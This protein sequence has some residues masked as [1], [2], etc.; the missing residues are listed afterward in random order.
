MKAEEIREAVLI[1]TGLL[2]LLPL[3]AAW[4]KDPD[5]PVGRR[6]ALDDFTFTYAPSAQALYHARQGAGCPADALL[7]VE[8]PDG[9]LHFTGPEVS[10]VLSHFPGRSV[11]L[12]RAQATKK[13]VVQAVGSSSVLHFSGHGLAGWGEAESSLLKLADGSLTLLEIF[14]LNLDQARLAVLSACETGVPG[15]KLPDEAV[16]LPSAWMQAGVP[17]VVGSLWCVEDM[18]TAMLMARFYDLW[19]DGDLSPPQ[20]LRQA[21]IWLRDSKVKDLLHQFRDRMPS[22]RLRMS[23]EAAE[24]FYKHK[25]IAWGE[26]EDRLFA[27]PVYWAAFTYTGL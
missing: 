12:L 11:H 4:T 18:S 22:A 15:I 8:N 13:N 23:A 21:Q 6:Y 24:S 26:P 3:H 27:N 9:T 10:S 2:G 17:G 25:R 1:P 5:L 7:A 14:D 16:S 19:R 20:A